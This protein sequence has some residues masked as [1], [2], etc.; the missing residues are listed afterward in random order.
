MYADYTYLDTATPTHVP[1]YESAARG[2][3]A[4][5]AGGNS[6]LPKDRNRYPCETARPPEN[7]Q[8][9]NCFLDLLPHTRIQT[10]ALATMTSSTRPG[11]VS[12]PPTAPA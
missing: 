9:R 11:R 10:P 2:P 7:D 12:L 6:G 1:A 8:S 4:G 3:A 5:R